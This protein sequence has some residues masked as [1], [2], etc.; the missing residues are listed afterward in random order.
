MNRAV[1]LAVFTSL[2]L[3]APAGTGAAYAQ[4]D[5]ASISGVVTDETGAVLPGVAV[6]ASSPSLIERT[7]TGVT[8]SSGRYAIIDLRPGT[9]TVTISL[10]GF[11]T[12]RREGI[13]LEGAFAAQVNGSLAVGSVEETVTVSGSTPVVDVQST[14]NQFVANQA[15]L[16]ALPVAR[17]LNGGMSLVPGVNAT[18]NAA[19]SSSGQILS[20]L[21]INTGTVTGR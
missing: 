11:R 16:E 5:R 3:A 1:K 17:T 20:D 6:E 4:G 9:Y 18:N 19:G 14:R 8:D 2:C 13:L 10:Q 15:V 21:Y 7:R 12:V